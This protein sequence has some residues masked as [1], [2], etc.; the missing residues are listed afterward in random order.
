MEPRLKSTPNSVLPVW[1]THLLPDY[2]FQTIFT[3]LLQITDKTNKQRPSLNTAGIA[4]SVI[5]I[6]DKN[7]TTQVFR[8]HHSNSSENVTHIDRFA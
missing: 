8:V 1:E 3:F 5:S 4:H 7:L 2:E 6:H